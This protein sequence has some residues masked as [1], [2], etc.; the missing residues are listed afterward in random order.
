M[1]ILRP[2]LSGKLI[3]LGEL[4]LYLCKSTTFINT[5]AFINYEIKKGPLMYNVQ[6]YVQ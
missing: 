2:S 6:I 5:H 4:V 1:L 3:L